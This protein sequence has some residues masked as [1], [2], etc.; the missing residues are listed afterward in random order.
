M[1]GVVGSGGEF[2]KVVSRVKG[3]VWSGNVESG[4]VGECG[5]VWS[6]WNCFRRLS[7]LMEIY[8]YIYINA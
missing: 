1:V 6:E 8:L 4:R 3:V 5:R 7:V 2:R